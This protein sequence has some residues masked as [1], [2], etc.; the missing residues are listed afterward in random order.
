MAKIDKIKEQL[1]TLRVLLSLS[2]GLILGLGAG[3]SNLYDRKTFDIRFYLSIIAINLLIVVILYI[4]KKFVKKQTKLKRNK[5]VQDILLT[6][7]LIFF[8]SAF[9]YVIKENSLTHSKH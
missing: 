8:I 7:T 2:V 9:F 1:N 3:V 5:M 4:G 6:S